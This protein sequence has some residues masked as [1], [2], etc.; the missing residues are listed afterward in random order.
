M[1]RSER[2]GSSPALYQGLV[3]LGLTLLREE[4]LPPQFAFRDGPSSPYFKQNYIQIATDAGLLLGNI[5]EGVKPVEHWLDSL[6][7][8]CVTERKEYVQTV[9]ELGDK[10]SSHRIQLLCEASATFCAWLDV[11]AIEEASL[12]T[13]G[14]LHRVVV[15]VVTKTWKQLEPNEQKAEQSAGE[16]AND[17][18]TRAQLRETYF[19]GFPGE[20]IKVLDVCWAAEQHYREWKRWLQ[21]SSTIK[22]GSTADLAFRKILT[23]GKRPIEYRPIA[24]PNNWQ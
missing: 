16:Q 5:P 9:T 11:H 3:R 20:K 1:H 15:D 19:A 24:R 10:S 8:F 13:S 18:P 6:V 17:L 2:P 23:S 7:A 22:N 4:L 12:G 21:N 14:K